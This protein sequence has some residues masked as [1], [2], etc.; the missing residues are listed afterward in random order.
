MRKP[1]PNRAGALNHLEVERKVSLN[2]LCFLLG[3]KSHSIPKSM[4]AVASPRENPVMEDVRKERGCRE[5]VGGRM[6]LPASYTSLGTCV[7]LVGWGTTRL[8]SAYKRSGFSGVQPVLAE[9]GVLGTALRWIGVGATR[10]RQQLVSILPCVF[11]PHAAAMGRI[12][13]RGCAAAGGTREGSGNSRCLQQTWARWH[14]SA[15]SD[16][17]PDLRMNPGLS[18]TKNQLQ[19]LRG[20]STIP[21]LVS[22]PVFFKISVWTRKTGHRSLSQVMVLSWLALHGLSCLSVHSRGQWSSRMW[23]GLWLRSW[24]VTRTKQDA[25]ICPGQHP[26][27]SPAFYLTERS[28]ILTIVFKCC[29]VHGPS[30]DAPQL[31]TDNTA[32]K[33]K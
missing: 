27:P 24:L 13:A 23:Y 15:L 26:L 7:G 3:I 6:W 9:P 31:L 32:G 4:G 17:G 18:F 8:L 5:E 33:Y 25:L 14:Q 10:A 22:H 19:L 28:W 29:Q 16:L 30:K 21:A 11:A 12:P 1:L 20:R 2:A